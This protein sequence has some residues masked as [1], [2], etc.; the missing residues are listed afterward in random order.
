M[1]FLWT[2]TSLVG[3]SFLGYKIAVMTWSCYLGYINMTYNLRAI[4][5]VMNSAHCTD[6]ITL[7]SRP[8]PPTSQHYASISKGCSAKRHH[9][10]LC[11]KVP[12]TILEGISY[13]AGKRHLVLCSKAAPCTMLK[14]IILYHR[15]LI[16]DS[17]VREYW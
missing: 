2:D 11:W 5:K 7:K 9:V 12:C 14:G 1:Q 13:Y 16:N 6:A 8:R 10:I 3:L 15:I 17:F 4:I